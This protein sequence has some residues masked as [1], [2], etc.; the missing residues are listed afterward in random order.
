MNRRNFLKTSSVVAGLGMFPLNCLGE[1]VKLSSGKIDFGVGPKLPNIVYIL[2]DDMGY[3]DLECQNPD[4]TPN[5]PTPNLN[6]LAAEGMRFTDAH[7]P[8]AV[9]TPTRYS[10]LTGRYCWRSRLKSGVL[11]PYGSPLIEDDRLTVQ[12]MLKRYGYDTGCIGK[13]HLGMQWMKNDGT[14]VTNGTNENNDAVIDLSAPI[15]KGPNSSG[16]DY[17]FGVD[18]PNFPPYAFIENQNVLGT[19]PWISKTSDVF[20]RAGRMQTGWTQEPILP[21]LRDKAI[22]FISDK[23][24][25]AP[26]KPFF[27]YM[28][29]TGPHTPIAP[30]D[31]FIGRSQAHLYGDFMCEIDALVGDVLKTIDRLGIRDNTLI[32][33]T[34]DNG[35]PARSGA[36]Y[37]GGLRTVH[38]YGHIPAGDFRGIKAD[39]WEGGHRV[40]FI[41]RWAGKIN[42]NTTN[43]ETICHVDLFATVASIVGFKLPNNVAEDSYNILPALLGQSYASPLREATVHHSIDGIFCIRKGKWKF[44]DGTGSGGWSGTGDGLQGQLYDMENDPEES[45]NL[46]ESPSHQTIIT[47]LKDLLQTY[48]N[49]GYSR[50][51]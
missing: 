9:C 37:E 41:A 19:E 14:Y 22:S 42:P 51:M 10:I 50:S 30:N 12:K 33:F 36:N 24:K 23:V 2:A 25:N 43:D 44:I 5:I 20:G 26:G 16:F 48:K 40:P 29:L 18:A 3:A 49:Q 21:T 39:A 15:G 28:P 32:I 11:R 31:N 45:N 27:L 1:G 13:W 8:A 38:N 17:Y 7:S 46:Y 35:S 34:S 47:E 4:P 6:Q